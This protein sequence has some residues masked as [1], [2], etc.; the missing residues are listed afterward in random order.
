MSKYN[1]RLT[2]K[3]RVERHPDKTINYEGGEAFEIS[4][5]RE[6]LYVMIASSLMGE[7]KFYISGNVHDK[8]IESVVSEV[9]KTDPEFLLKLATYV[10]TELYLRSAPIFLLGNAAYNVETKPFVRKY[11]PYI[12]QR[13]D[14]LVEVL[15]FYKNKFL[16]GKQKHT[17]PAS[18]K[19]GVARSFKK[20]D[21]Y[22]FGKYNRDGEMK[23]RDALR[24]VIGQLDERAEERRTLYQ[25]ILDNT[26]ETPD[27]WE[28]KM[29]TRGS[30]TENWQ[31]MLDGGKMGIFA[32][33]R[34]LRNML[35]KNVKM[36]K[37]VE[38][39]ENPEVIA[40]SKMFPFRFYQALKEIAGKNQRVSDALRVA[41]NLASERN[42][43]KLGGKT[44]VSVDLSGSMSGLLSQ[45]S[46][47][48]YR[49]VGSLMGAM[50]R[51][52]S[53]DALVSAFGERFKTIDLSNM[54]TVMT[55]M[56]RINQTNVGHATFG[57]LAIK[58]LIDNNIKVDRI[59]LFTDTELYNEHG[60]LGYFSRRGFVTERDGGE[61][62]ATLMKEYKRKVN[63]NVYLY[64]F[65]LTGYGTSTF[66]RDEKNYALISGWSEQVF[67][68]VDMF[69]KDPAS[70]IKYIKEKY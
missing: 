32:I 13:A 60:R 68:F 25:K 18:L 56:E 69:E 57:Y 20:F 28:V 43:P 19:K 47:I 36:D 29:S 5:P 1:T 40:K 61:T 53:D 58:Y 45:R 38:L 55:N 54:D 12:I 15:Q 33:V 22:Q 21:E 64:L 51:H 37:A 30:T 50:A 48:T 41:V 3:Q 49:E 4:D 24:I 31:E 59:M 35:D 26:L 46:S 16:G 34:N 27:T 39:L 6:R 42:L 17:F 7:D 66:P 11:A 10:R 52:F 70:V 63:P 2:S 44:F 9:I 14:E 65:D 62:I 23:L 67:K 8:E